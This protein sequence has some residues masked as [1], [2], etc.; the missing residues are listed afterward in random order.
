MNFTSYNLLK[1]PLSSEKY[2]I[3][4]FNENMDLIDSA[5]NK[6]SLRDSSLESQITDHHNNT[7]NPHSVT[8]SQIG[9][10]NVENK[11]SK[12]IRSE[13]TKS[14]VTAALG[15]TPYTP[16]EIDNKFSAIPTATGSLDGLLSKENYLNYEDAN[17]KKHIHDNKAVI[18]AITQASLDSW[19]AAASHVTSGT[20]PHGTTKADIGLGN[21]KNKSST[22]ANTNTVYQKDEPAGSLLSGMVWIG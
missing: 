22:A 12:A 9:L 1:K 3:A 4:V 17:S 8:K 6:G 16:A 21:V 10:E 20:N 5:L 2:D 18:D 15:Y 11:S 19:N 7:T 14:D 13:I